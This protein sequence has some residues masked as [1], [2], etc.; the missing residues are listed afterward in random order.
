M[1]EAVQVTSAKLDPLTVLWKIKIP[2]DFKVKTEE[3]QV[4]WVSDLFFP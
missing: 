2:E 1:T 3:H 4:T